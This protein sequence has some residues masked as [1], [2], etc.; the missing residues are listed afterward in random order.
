MK[1]QTSE[2]LSKKLDELDPRLYE[3]EVKPFQIEDIESFTK[4]VNSDSTPQQVS[5]CGTY[6]ED[7]KE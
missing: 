3:I 1:K 4:F 2:D 7:V 5:K 6:Y